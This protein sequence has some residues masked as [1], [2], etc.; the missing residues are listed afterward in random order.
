MTRLLNILFL[1]LT[2]SLLIACRPGQ[3]S[4]KGHAAAETSSMS[5]LAIDFAESLPDSLKALALR[6]FEDTARLAWHFF[7]MKRSGVALRQLDATQREKLFALLE[8]GLSAQGM[9]RTRTIMSL[10]SVLHVLENREAGDTFRD[11]EAYHLTIFGVPADDQVWSWRFEGHHVSLNYTAAGGG[12]ISATPN[13]MGSNPAKVRQGP[14]EGLEALV[15]EEEMGRALYFM[16]D[17][18]QQKQVIL[19]DTAP[20]E[21][22]TFV[23][24]RVKMEVY[25][26]LSASEMNSQQKDALRSLIEVYTGRA[27]E[28]LAAPYWARI[29]SVGFDKL[30]FAWAGSVEKGEP[31]YYRVHGPTLLI[32]YDNVQN[33]AN[34]AHSV[35]RDPDR[36]FAYDW[37]GKHHQSAS[38]HQQD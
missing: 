11:P 10:E 22:V 17:D 38:H 32:E 9:E 25:E 1:G 13:F 21:I 8:S 3:A 4:S 36:D 16:L 14:S 33:G 18:A 5:E 29:D 23:D 12:R 31:M 35:W 2:M 19:R 26:G 20:R 24:Q 27:K 30:Y 15:G 7:P 37:L 6:G 28:P 34:H